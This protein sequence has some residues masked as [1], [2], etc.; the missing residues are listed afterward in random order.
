MPEIGDKFK[1]QRL[2]RRTFSFVSEQSKGDIVWWNFYDI[3]SGKHHAFYPDEV[4]PV[5]EYTRKARTVTVAD[6]PL[7]SPEREPQTITVEGEEIE[8]I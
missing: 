2:P 1:V 8:I 7:L 4:V 5:G 3:D 6:P